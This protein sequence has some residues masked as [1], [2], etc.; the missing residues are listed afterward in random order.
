LI[1]YSLHKGFN[2]KEAIYEEE[3]MIFDAE[4]KKANPNC[5]IIEFQ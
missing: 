5:Y 4:R 3:F 1:R 2:L